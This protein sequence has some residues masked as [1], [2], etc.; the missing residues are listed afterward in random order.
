MTHLLYGA[1]TDNI[2][3]GGWDMAAASALGAFWLEKYRL[4][5]PMRR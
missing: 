4:P 5:E 1:A 3:G 2:G